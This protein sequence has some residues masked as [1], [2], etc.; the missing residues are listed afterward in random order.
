MHRYMQ[1]ERRTEQTK[2]SRIKK[3]N[4]KK[5]R[6]CRKRKTDKQRKCAVKKKIIKN[7]RL[8]IRR[9]LCLKL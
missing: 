8:R 5:E 6:F 1:I 9:K 2:L 3:F 7:L 4:R